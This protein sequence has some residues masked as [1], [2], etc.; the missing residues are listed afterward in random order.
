MTLWS[1]EVNAPATA[2]SALVVSASPSL[3]ASLKAGTGGAGRPGSGG[4]D[5]R[6]GAP[7]PPEEGWGASARER[8]TLR[9]A[10]LAD[11]AHRRLAHVARCIAELRYERNH[12]A[13]ITELEGLITPTDA[14]YVVN[15][16]EV[17]DPIH[18][19]DW[20]LTIGGLVE[21]PIELSLKEARP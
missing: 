7:P 15:Q 13:P 21:R 1:V 4:R 5:P 12:R 17:P 20:T 3:V 14:Y 9:V 6:L 11:R 18:P 16:L 19:D 10:E 8:T 2:P